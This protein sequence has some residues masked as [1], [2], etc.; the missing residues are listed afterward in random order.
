MLDEKNPGQEPEKKAPEPIEEDDE[1]QIR[2]SAKDY[3]IARKNRKIEKLEA[4]KAKNDNID[5]IFDDDFDNKKEVT[6]RDIVQEEIEPLKSKIK[7][8]AD[9][10][11]LRDAISKYP[12]AKG[13]EKTIRKYMN[14]YP[15]AAVEFI[16][17]GLI[18]KKRL[19]DEKKKK[20][21]EEAKGEVIEGNSRRTPKESKI[22]DVK[23]M[24]DE[25]FNKLDNDVMS[26]KYLPK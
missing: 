18:G 21:E 11:E 14:A 25:E 13:M 4:E 20:A 7:E 22:P 23:N 19:L 9:E 3:I 5:D 24:S 15:N 8:T 1:P 12:E 17:L 2:R 10:Q 26:G 16:T 6:S